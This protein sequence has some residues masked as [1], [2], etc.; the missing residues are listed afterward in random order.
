M[1]KVVYIAPNF[2]VAEHLKSLLE[3]EGL[4]VTLRGIG[5]EGEGKGPVE[6]LVPESEAEEAY[7]IINSSLIYG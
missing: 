1:W 4:L 7:E 2:E 6:M 3:G 5:V